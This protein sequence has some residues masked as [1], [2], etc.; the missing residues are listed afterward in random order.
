MEKTT[1]KISRKVNVDIIR[2]LAMLMV[3]Y[4]HTVYSFTMRSDFFATKSWFI[5]EPF[6]ALS[7]AS[8]TLFFMISGFL[9][10]N[11]N[12]TVKENWQITLNRIIIPLIFFTIFDLL[13]QVYKYKLSL[14]SVWSQFF[15]SLPKYPNNWLWFLMVLLLEN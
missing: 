4:L 10:T 3:I 7:K 6:A 15:A 1:Q 2:V 5:F 12:R 13:F 8:I 14:V 9:L 11:K